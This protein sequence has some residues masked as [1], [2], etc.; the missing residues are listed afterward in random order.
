M[1]EDVRVMKNKSVAGCD[2]GELTIA[3]LVLPAANG[4]DTNSEWLRLPP[5]RGRLH[6][7]SRTGWCELLDSG[8]VKGII[9]RKKHAKRGIRLIHRPS[10]D[11]Y[12]RSLLGEE[13]E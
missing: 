6:G 1:H 3:P 4:S 10:A 11:T 13:K 12:L 7:L 9:L 2:G 8:K 5:P